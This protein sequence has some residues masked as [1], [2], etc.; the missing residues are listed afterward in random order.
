[1]KKLD[2]NTV[3]LDEDGQ[4]G[5]REFKDIIKS[6]LKQISAEETFK[7]VTKF[8]NKKLLHNGDN[9]D[10]KVGQTKRGIPFFNIGGQN[11]KSNIFNT[12]SILTHTPKNALRTLLLLMT[13]L[14]LNV[15]QEKI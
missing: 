3:E 13:I 14:M 6:Q 8:N 4:I 9:K 7:P 11:E 5:Q 15:K 1:M 12:F 10:N 2:R